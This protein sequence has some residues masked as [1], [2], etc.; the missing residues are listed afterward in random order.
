MPTNMAD[1]VE[2]SGLFFDRATGKMYREDGS[3]TGFTFEPARWT[4][5]WGLHFNWPWL[6]PISFA[7]AE[8]A[9][10]VLAWARQRVRRGVITFAVD[11]TQRVVGPF[12]RTVERLIAASDGNRTETFSAGWLANSIIRNGEPRAAESF[13]AEIALAWARR[14]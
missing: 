11:D 3:D 8:T 6:N 5:P 14:D 1:L 13:A 10:Q 2:Y 7:T 4:G 9:E 12:T